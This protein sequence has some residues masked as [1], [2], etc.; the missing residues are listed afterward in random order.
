MSAKTKSEKEK[1]NKELYQ[2]E[3]LYQMCENVKAICI[4]PIT[5]TSNK[6]KRTFSQ[7]FQPVLTP[8]LEEPECEQEAEAV[9]NPVEAEP[10]N[11]QNRK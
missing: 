10:P 3:K 8:W 2:Q 7:A 6:N 5:K 1:T 11:K 4:K 9:S